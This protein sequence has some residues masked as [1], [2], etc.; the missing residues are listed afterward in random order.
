MKTAPVSRDRRAMQEHEVYLFAHPDDEF[1]VFF[2]L[3]QAVA[4]GSTVLCLYLTDGAF[5]GQASE[6]R[7]AE[8][9]SVLRRL[10]I[11]QAFVRFIGAEEGFA[12]GALCGRIEDAYRAVEKVL[13]PIARIAALHVHAW[14]GGHQDHDAV[15]LIGVAYAAK[16]GLLQVARQFPLYRAGP[17]LLNI[18]TC[19]PLMENGPILSERIPFGR[20]LKYIYLCFTYRSQWRSFLFLLPMLA[21]H[22]VRKGTQDFQ[23]IQSARIAGPAHEGPLLYER[24]GFDSYNKFRD[25]SETFLSLHCRDL[26]AS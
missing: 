26:T 21:W 11:D 23:E 13:D 2:S 1:G 17:G 14:E 20:R 22:Y 8:T 19:S 7:Q 5:G 24:R 9:L 15:H 18:S 25:A 3:E 6:R 16:R 4:R 10:G 12:D